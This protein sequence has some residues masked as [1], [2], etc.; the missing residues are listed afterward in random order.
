MAAGECPDC[1]AG[2]PI[3][4]DKPSMKGITFNGAIKRA[5]LPSG[6]SIVIVGIGG[7]RHIGTQLAKAMVHAL[8]FP[9]VSL[10]FFKSYR[11][12]N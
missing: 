2:R 7:L 10:F 12:R 6:G 3:Y 8:F 5:G 4:C 9:L 11:G 1:K